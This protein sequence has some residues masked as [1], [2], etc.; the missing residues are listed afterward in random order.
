MNLQRIYHLV[1]SH[2]LSS[3]ILK[4]T[5]NRFKNYRGCRFEIVFE[6]IFFIF[7]SIKGL[8]I[9]TTVDVTLNILRYHGIIETRKFL[10]GSGDIE[11]IKNSEFEC[12]VNTLNISGIKLKYIEKV[13]LEAVFS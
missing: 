4:D 8:G 12:F 5:L 1:F 9:L 2:C 13:F 11:E 10:I 3:K 7:K 6:S